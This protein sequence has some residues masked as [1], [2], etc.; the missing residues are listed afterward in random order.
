MEANNTDLKLHSAAAVTLGTIIGSPLA[1][2]FLLAQNYRALDNAKAARSCIIWGASTTL[3]IIGLSFFLKLPPLIFP[4]CY[5]IALYNLANSLQGP[6]YRQ[7]I[8]R[9]GRKASL[10]IA[11]GVGFAYMFV[12]YGFIRLL[13]LVIDGL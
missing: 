2:T 4:I 13:A 9:G 1:G 10:W 11:V 7:H 5:T 8:E 3:I 6:A 12:L